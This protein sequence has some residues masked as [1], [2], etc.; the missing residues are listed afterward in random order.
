MTQNKTKINNLFRIIKNHDEEKFLKF[1][2]IEGKDLL[3]LPHPGSTQFPVHRAAETG[4]LFV[5][6]YLRS[7]P[8]ARI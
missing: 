2:E 7:G 3:S 5:L 1:I 4:N 6:E 8:M